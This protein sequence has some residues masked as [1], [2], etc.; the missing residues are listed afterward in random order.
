[1]AKIPAFWR[2][3]H[4]P[5]S[6][7]GPMHFPI[8]SLIF[9]VFQLGGSVHVSPKVATW[10]L[11]WTFGEDKATFVRTTESSAVSPFEALKILE[12]GNKRHFEKY[13]V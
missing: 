7:S 1:M 11:A 12:E 3:R 9:Q 6:K 5:D 10:S 4:D 8:F 13:G 2:E